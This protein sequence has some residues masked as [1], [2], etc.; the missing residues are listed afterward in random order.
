MKSIKKTFLFFIF[1]IITALLCFMS[2]CLCIESSNVAA[3]NIGCFKMIDAYKLRLNGNGFSFT[4]KMDEDT[5]NEIN[6]NLFFI[7]APKTAFDKCAENGKSFDALLTDNTPDV[8]LVK[9]VDIYRKEGDNSFWYANGGIVNIS[10]KKRSTEYAAVAA[11]RSISN[12]DYVYRLADGLSFNNLYSVLIGGFYG[13]NDVSEIM[14]YYGEWLGTDEYPIP[15]DTQEDYTA[16]GSVMSTQKGAR[17]IS[18]KKVEIDESIDIVDDLLERYAVDY[19]ITHTV[20][21]LNTDGAV[22]YMKTHIKSGETPRYKGDIPTMPATENLYKYSFIGWDKEVAPINANTDYTAQYSVEISEEYGQSAVFDT[23]N[24][25]N[26]VSVSNWHGKTNNLSFDYKLSARNG[27]F[28]FALADKNGALLSEAVTVRGNID[29]VSLGDGWYRYVVGLRSLA[30]ITG[31]K[32]SETVAK[33]RFDTVDENTVLYLKNVGTADTCVAVDNSETFVAGSWDSFIP[34]DNVSYTEKVLKFDFKPSKDDGTFSVRMLNSNSLQI[35]PTIVI[36]YSGSVNYGTVKKMSDGRFRFEIKIC[37]I[38]YDD[39]SGSNNFY[40]IYFAD[41]TDTV[42]I[43][44]VD[45][46][47]SSITVYETTTFAAG[48][49]EKF[50]PVHNWKQSDGELAFEYKPLFGS[51]AD[52]VGIMLYSGAKRVADTISLKYDGTANYGSV[53]KLTDGWFRFRVRVSDLGIATGADGSETFDALKIRNPSSAIVFDNVVTNGS[54]TSLTITSDTEFVIGD[55]ENFVAVERWKTSYK[56]LSFDYKPTSSSGF[57]CLQFNKGIQTNTA[58][59]VNL[60]YS[61]Y[62]DVGTVSAIGNG[63]YHYEVALR[64]LSPQTDTG[65]SGVETFCAL[66]FSNLTSALTVDH[67]ETVTEKYLLTVENGFGGG[68]FEKGEKVYITCND[69]VETD[70]LVNSFVGW[71]KSES[72]SI[73]STDRKILIEVSADATYTAVFDGEEWT[74]ILN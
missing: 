15:V 27:S 20:R 72:G 53:E 54:D 10:E 22:L 28:S 68:L 18:G 51:N 47:D 55:W 6:D 69:D 61:G 66:C 33:I 65:N 52:S 41:L 67:I 40:Q 23:T 49:W 1:T 43:D 14:N 36:D 74:G 16:L 30:I 4:V 29:G 32:G 59:S 58:N 26:F 24:W 38:V 64:F 7:I 48:E 39:F 11:I 3:A 8:S 25:Q 5:K 12:G 46:T 60:Y 17:F 70:T 21:W 50:F 31:K 35:A 57:V 13:E 62:A 42:R 2:V 44:N 56:V 9:S 34:V 71:K 37:S 63:W 19:T 45:T 73:V